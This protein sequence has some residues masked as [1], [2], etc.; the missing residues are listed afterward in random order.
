MPVF[1]SSTAFEIAQGI[2]ALLNLE[3]GITRGKTP[4]L[5][6]QDCRILRRRLGNGERPSLEGGQRAYYQE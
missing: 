1:R 2:E 5:P 4:T 3:A 6:S